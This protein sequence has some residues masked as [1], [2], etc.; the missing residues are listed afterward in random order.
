MSNC[1]SCNYI[2]GHSPGCLYFRPPRIAALVKELREKGCDFNEAANRL[3][4][5]A[6]ALEQELETVYAHDRKAQEDFPLAAECMT[7]G[8]QAPESPCEP[9][10][11][12]R[13]MELYSQGV[14]NDLQPRKETP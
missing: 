8:C 2:V 14:S 13:V 6:E 11:C 12:K 3:Q 4:E 5:L 9:P 10:G 1:E 7:L